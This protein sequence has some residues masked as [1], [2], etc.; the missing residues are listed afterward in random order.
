[1]KSKLLR[2]LISMFN[3]AQSAVRWDGVVGDNITS[4]SGVLQGGIVSPNLFNHYLYDIGNYLEKKDGMQLRTYT[5]EVIRP[6]G[7]VIVDVEHAGRTAPLTA[8]IVPGPGPNLL[9]RDWLADL[10]L[11]W[12]AVRQFRDD[13]FLEAFTELFQEDLGTLNGTEVKLVVDENVKP[14][15]C[16]PRPVPFAMQA[17]VEAELDRLQKEGV[18]RPVTYSDWA[19][20][21]VPV[22]KSS[23]DLRICGDYSVTI[24]KAVKGD[25]YPIPNIQDL[26]AKLSGGQIF[27]K[28]DLSHA[29]Q[30]LML[31]EESPMLTAINTTK[32]LFVYNRMPFGI[33]AAPGIFQR[34]MERLIQ[35]IPMTVVY[36]D[37][38]LV[39]GHT[40][41]EHHTHLKQ[42]LERLQKAGLRLKREKC[43]FGRPSC[44]YL[45][46]RIDGEGIHPTEEK[47][48]AIINAP[49]PRNVAELRSF[50]GLVN[51]YHRFIQNLSTQCWHHFMNSCKKVT[52][53][54]GAA[55][56]KWHLRSQN[57]C[58]PQHECWSIMIHDY[59]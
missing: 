43:S 1:M 45:G 30:Q 53:G 7:R 29:Y 18:I 27:S 49:E 6:L 9:G 3:K 21:I 20:P 40:P 44:T 51:Y 26:Y 42:V 56:R 39:T 47:V 10:K 23:G 50:L 48:S 4:K 32:G 46:H 13:D 5:R 37:D 35:G 55:A 8:I 31:D 28:I 15:F 33:S 24:N 38:I 54:F 25:K 19:A 59:P 11:D 12:A 2:V 52:D 34:T 16:K 41:E 57:S 58:W 14:H 17:K 36:L 22:L